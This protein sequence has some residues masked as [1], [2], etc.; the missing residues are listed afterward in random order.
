MKLEYLNHRTKAGLL[1]LADVD[2]VA[3][4]L[5][6]GGLAVLP[7]ETGYMLAALATDEP[8]IIAAFAVKGRDLAHTVHVAFSSLAMARK[9]AQLTPVAQRIL[10]ASTP[11]PVTVV[12]N[13]SGLLPPRLV[14]VDGTVGVRVPDHPIT[15]Q[16]IA[17]V[18]A[19][20]TATSLNRA[21]ESAVDIAAHELE[22]L[23]WPA[24]SI[25][26]VVPDDGSILYPQP[27]TLVRLTG[28]EM[29][30]LRIGPISEANLRA[31]L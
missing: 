25:V 27:S 19:P 17:A 21:G 3:E 8:A 2:R 1:P 20:L 22:T 29:E 18:G 7:T 9:Y 4:E 12:V 5:R 10:G 31:L 14:T 13:Q 16:V 11:G 15:A 28:A 26:Y 6:A 23:S 24:D 30:I